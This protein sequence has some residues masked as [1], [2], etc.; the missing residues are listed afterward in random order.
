MFIMSSLL[1][2]LSEQIPDSGALLLAAPVNDRLWPI[3]E[4]TAGGRGVRYWGAP[5]AVGDHQR[6]SAMSAYHIGRT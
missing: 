3:P 1:A 6:A 5:A 2:R 4:M